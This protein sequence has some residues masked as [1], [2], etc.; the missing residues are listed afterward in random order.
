MFIIRAFV[1]YRDNTWNFQDIPVWESLYRMPESEG[2]YHELFDIIY[3]EGIVSL[4]IQ[5]RYT[6]LDQD[7]ID[8][9]YEK[10]YGFGSGNPRLPK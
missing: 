5:D 10:Y 6:I 3:R 9:C 4:K 1:L 8:Y 2:L 7:E